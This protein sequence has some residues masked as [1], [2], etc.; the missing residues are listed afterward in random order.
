LTGL[1]DPGNQAP[2][3]VAA[4]AWINAL[5]AETP[6]SISYPAN[7]NSNATAS[8]T[9]VSTTDWEDNFILMMACS[10]DF[11]KRFAV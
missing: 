7:V 4:T 1:A 10:A 6:L 11:G 9:T 8:V 3:C 2:W 5:S